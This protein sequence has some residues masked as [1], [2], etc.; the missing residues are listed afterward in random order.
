MFYSL[1]NYI[2]S[3]SI[4]LPIHIIDNSTEKKNKDEKHKSNNDGTF[5]WSTN[6]SNIVYTDLETGL[7]KYD[8]YDV[9]VK[10]M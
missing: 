3:Q 4:V 8:F 5:I 10:G 2:A 9:W 6:G 7:I 1:L